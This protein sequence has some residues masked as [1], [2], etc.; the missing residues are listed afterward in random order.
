MFES[1]SHDSAAWRGAKAEYEFVLKNPF[2]DDVQ[3][4]GAYASMKERTSVEV[5]KPALKKTYERF[6]PREAEHRSVR[7]STR[8]HLRSISIVRNGQRFA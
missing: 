5:T 8:G 4:S 7:R 6:D 3:I 1:T 2:M